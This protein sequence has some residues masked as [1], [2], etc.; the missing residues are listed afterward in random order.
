MALWILAV[1][2]LSLVVTRLIAAHRP[3][4]PRKTEPFEGTA[5]RFYSS[6]IFARTPEQPRATV[7]CMHGFL[8]TPAYFTHGYADPSLQ[9]ILI[10]SADYDSPFTATNTV[11][12]PWAQAV[13]SAPGTIEHDAEILLIAMRN[14]IRG[15]KV[16]VH[17]H[18]RGGAVVIEAARR[19]PVLFRD[20]EVVLEAAV[21]PQGQLA[22][23]GMNAVTLWVM[24]LV[25]ML[26]RLQ[27]ISNANKKTFGRLDDP[28][29]ERLIRSM[30][31][32]PNRGS[33]AVTNVDSIVKWSKATPVEV[34]ATIR[35]KVFIA[36]DDRVLKSSAMRTVVKAAPQLEVIEV[37]DSSH[38]V[39]LDHPGLFTVQ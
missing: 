25:L 27:P 36:D 19:D 4:G 20:V 30:P 9:L 6:W 21:L 3:L 16:R 12:A 28:R 31:T 10:G 29:K 15:P 23:G 1:V 11:P 7:L 22:G 18:S 14:L 24:P 2:V 35:G 8:E 13:R 17:G 38:F 37:K 32:N 5:H 33:T 34:L 26:W 39:L